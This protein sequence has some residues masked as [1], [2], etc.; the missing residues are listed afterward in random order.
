V[1]RVSTTWLAIPAATVAEI[2]AHTEPAPLPLAPP[3]VPGVINLRGHAVPLLDLQ[4]LLD[5][6]LGRSG[7]T[8][9]D[10]ALFAYFGR[11]AVVSVA[12]MRVG[13]LCNQVRGVVEIARDQ[14]HKP[15]VTQGRKLLEFATSEAQYADGILIFLDLIRLMQ[16]AKVQK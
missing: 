10:D 16:A 8:E 2:C 11:I 7:A 1:F 4:L 5:L 6:P 9:G 15:E 3:H 12:N 14:L 13:I